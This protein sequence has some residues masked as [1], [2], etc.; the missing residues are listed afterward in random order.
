MGPA[1]SW[2]P[3]E[4]GEKRHGAALIPGSRQGRTVGEAAGLGL[5][6]RSEGQAVWLTGSEVQA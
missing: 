5:G 4:V 3:V 2:G 6:P 1:R